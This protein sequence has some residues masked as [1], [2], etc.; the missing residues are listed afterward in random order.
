MSCNTSKC[1]ELVLKKSG[2]AEK[3]ISPSIKNMEQCPKLNLMGVTF[4]SNGK[5]TEHV[6][7]MLYSA[8]R[9]KEKS[10]LSLRKREL[11]LLFNSL[12]IS[13][14]SYGLSVYGSSTSD[15]YIQCSAY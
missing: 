3:Y 15:L 4:Q 5:F 12:V 6:K 8:K 7:N 9:K 13:K 10:F 1:K 14:I 2:R 11:N